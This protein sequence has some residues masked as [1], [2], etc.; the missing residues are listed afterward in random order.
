MYPLPVVGFCIRCGMMSFAMGSASVRSDFSLLASEAYVSAVFTD[1]LHCQCG[2]HK[3]N[4]YCSDYCWPRPYRSFE[5]I[6]GLQRRDAP[7]HSAKACYRCR[8][9][10]IFR[11]G[12]GPQGGAIFG[13]Q[14]QENL[15]SLL[16]FNIS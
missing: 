4:S 9:I 14:G 10:K 1:N 16:F 12:S 3:I 5:L 6:L 2:S 7:R 15:N 11:L 13:K 8:R